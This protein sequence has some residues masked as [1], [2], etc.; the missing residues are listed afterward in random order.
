M[1]TITFHDISQYPAPD[2]NG[3]IHFKGFATRLN[4]RN[5]DYINL[6]ER[7]LQHLVLANTVCVKYFQVVILTDNLCIMYPYN[8]AEVEQRRRDSNNPNVQLDQ[9]FVRDTNLQNIAGSN[10]AFLHNPNVPRKCIVRMVE[11]DEGSTL[12]NSVSLANGDETET[13]IDYLQYIN[14]GTGRYKMPY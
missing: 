3:V 11:E 1:T 9:Y 8:I 4:L 12:T 13:P 6:T 10:V 2:P 14:N 7:L 5:S